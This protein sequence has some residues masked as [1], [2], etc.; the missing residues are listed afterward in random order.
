M[1][2]VCFLGGLRHDLIT[3]LIRADCEDSA[4]SDVLT[5][6]GWELLVTPRTV[7]CSNLRSQRQ[8]WGLKVAGKEACASCPSAG[9]LPTPLI[10][11]LFLGPQFPRLGYIDGQARVVQ[12]LVPSVWTRDTSLCI[13]AHL[14]GVHVSRSVSWGPL[15]SGA[16]FSQAYLG[17]LG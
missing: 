3:P 13:R 12:E 1:I 11:L 15:I 14:I 16:H 17:P 6:K 9:A 7:Q 4:S 2:V 8:Y 10:T 5:P